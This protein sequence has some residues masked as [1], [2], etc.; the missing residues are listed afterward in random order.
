MS[1]FSN[2]YKRL[3]EIK[4]QLEPLEREERAGFRNKEKK[5]K[6]EYQIFLLV[7]EQITIESCIKY[8]DKKQKAVE[9]K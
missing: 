2:P 3:E 8:F 6:C 1:N 7:I 5:E 9:K 4:I